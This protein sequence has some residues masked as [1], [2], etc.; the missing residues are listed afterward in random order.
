MKLQTTCLTRNARDV[1]RA[2]SPVWLRRR[3]CCSGLG[4]C[5]LA[6]GDKVVKDLEEL[7]T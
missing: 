1:R 3:C 7:P 5:S 4:G 6:K 2:P